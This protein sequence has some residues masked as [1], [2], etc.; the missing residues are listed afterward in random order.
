MQMTA[1]R[2][3]TGITFGYNLGQSFVWLAHPRFNVL[4]ETVF[5]RSQQVQS[6]S[7]GAED[8]RMDERFF[9]LARAFAG[10][11][12]FEKR[13]NSL[14]R[15]SGWTQQILEPRARV[16]LAACRLRKDPTLR[17]LL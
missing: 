13:L 12:H 16:E 8:Y 3:A 14:P 7:D 6:T 2:A 5:N 9:C 1:L 11:A 4:L 17:M 15:R 10:T